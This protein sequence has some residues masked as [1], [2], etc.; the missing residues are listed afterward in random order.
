MAHNVERGFSR[1]AG[2]TGSFGGRFA[3]PAALPLA[4]A[5]LAVVIL[6]P[7]LWPGFTLVFDM[8]FTPRQPVLPSGI[9]LG[10]ALPRAVPQDAAVALVTTVLPGALVQKVALAG[11][12]FGAAL[13]AGRLVPTGSLGVRLVAAVG[14]VWNAYVAER[15]F[16]GHWSLL[17][18]YAGLPW[19]VRAGLDLRAA[20]R[21]RDRERDRPDPDTSDGAA[22]TSDDATDPD[23]V[24]ESE[25]ESE[26]EPELVAGPAS[27]TWMGLARLALCALPAMLTATGGLLVAAAALVAA[28]RRRIGPVA[29]IMVGLNAPWL[30]PSLLAPQGGA[31]D[32][33][34]V[35]AFSARAEGVAGTPLSV[36]GLGGVWNAQVMPAS[37]TSPLL[38][39]A[40]LLTVAAAVAGVWV[41]AR[42]WGRAPVLGLS[43]LAAAGLVLALAGSVA[44]L[45]AA[46]RWAVANVPGAG[47]LRDGQKW[48]AWWALLVALGVALAV[49]R[50]AARLRAPGA[51]TA[52][53]AVLALLPVGLLPDLA[54]GGLGRLTSV[55][56]PADYTAVRDLLAGD[57]RPGAVAALPASAFRRFDWNGRRTQLDPAPRF[58]PREVITDDTLVVGGTAVQ[59]EDPRAAAV[60]GAVRAGRPLG[61][62]GVGWV[63]VENGGPGDPPDRAGP[64]PAGLRPVYEGA[65]L[66][67][68][69]VPGVVTAPVVSTARVVAV[70]A[71][72]TVAVAVLIWAVL[73]RLRRRRRSALWP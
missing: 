53:L 29:L 25:S 3:R 18:A 1:R 40:V 11:L 62:L 27:A 59:G 22:A 55:A 19:V 72:D 41:L 26:P 28:G 49:D 20:D 10:A 9:G 14:Y 44:P 38:P 4:A 34:A 17:V 69:R 45:S 23:A 56:Y 64:L 33:A 32:P 73:I 60:F 30:V 21:E 15:L 58:L 51:R 67:L 36:L 63:L 50:V 43:A 71:A 66:R 2:R 57:P 7:A 16:I 5:G 37:R 35:A 47:L 65:W 61:P 48:S 24:S 70:A 6:G 54:W 8:V 12:L 31:S 13:G 68:Y 52:L 46:L 39:V 42:R